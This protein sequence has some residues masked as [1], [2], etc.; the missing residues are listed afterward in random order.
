MYKILNEKVNVKKEQ[1]FRRS[2]TALNTR[3][4]SLKLEVQRSRLDKRKVFFSHRVVQ[5]W[6]S[7]PQQVVT[8]VS[9]NSFKNSFDKFQDMG[10][11]GNA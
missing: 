11:K 3:G 1:F 9:I 8:S 7:L 6:N 2:A 4:H 10:I 5:Q